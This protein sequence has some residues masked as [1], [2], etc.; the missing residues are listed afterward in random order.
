MEEKPYKNLGKSIKRGITEGKGAKIGN[1]YLNAHF[2]INKI[3]IYNLKNNPSNGL[4][5][6]AIINFF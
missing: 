3:H 5:G 6:V 4:A 1:Y 2:H